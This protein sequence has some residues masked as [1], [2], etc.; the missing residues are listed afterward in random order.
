MVI[1]K[2]LV[3]QLFP[4]GNPNENHLY[5]ADLGKHGEIKGKIALKPVYTADLNTEFTVSVEIYK[6]QAKLFS[7][8]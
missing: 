5:F 8:F 2:Y 3:L 7:K 4:N 6:I 1:G